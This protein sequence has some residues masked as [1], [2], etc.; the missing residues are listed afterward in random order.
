MIQSLTY[1]LSVL[2]KAVQHK[3]LSAAAVHVGLSQP[4]LSRLVAKIESELSIV[5]LDRSARR[6][7]GW[8]PLAHDLALTFT[9]GIGRLQSDILSMAQKSEVHELRIGTLEGL[10]AI[11][12]QFVQHCFDKAEIS[13][14][15]LDIL[16]F[17][18]LDSQ[19][20]GG[21]LDL[22]FTVRPPSKQKYKHQLEV[23]YQQMEVLST[24]KNIHV[25]SPYEFSSLDKKTIG[26]GKKILISN[27]LS[28]RSHWLHEVGGIGVLPIDAKKG[29]GKGYYSIFLIG[30]DLLSPH[31]WSKI[32]DFN[33]S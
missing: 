24:D 32:S 22:I 2:A 7:S 17:K 20:L 12:S 21:N 3:N 33:L 29:R 28:F 6:K 16:D 19:F 5:L 25:Y 11:A 26:P 13:T 8:T 23:G 1:E 30:S 15:Y 18:E 10:A 31:L 27:S 4:Q 9:K 14:A